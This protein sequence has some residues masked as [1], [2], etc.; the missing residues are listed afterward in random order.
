[1]SGVWIGGLD[2]GQELGGAM[3]CFWIWGCSGDESW[4]ATQ[5]WAR[6][7]GT[8]I[9][10]YASIHMPVPRHSPESEL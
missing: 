2:L 4:L 1:M 5:T 9:R 6:K 10:Q 7:F 8:S 3:C